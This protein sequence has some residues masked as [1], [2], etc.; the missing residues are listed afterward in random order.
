MTVRYV[1]LVQC[2]LHPDIKKHIIKKTDAKN[3]YMWHL[4]ECFHAE[5]PELIEAPFLG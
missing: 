5:P 4:R 2:P 3:Y 1:F